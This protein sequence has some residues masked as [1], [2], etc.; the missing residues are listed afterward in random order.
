MILLVDKGPAMRKK[1]CDMLNRER[2]IGVAT[3]QQVLETLV[4]H[5]NRLNVFIADATS[6][7]EILSG[8]TILKL[9][10][11][12]SIN[13]PPI[14]ALYRPGQEAIIQGIS[15]SNFQ[16]E[17]V[18]FDEKDIDFPDAYTRAIKTVYPEV[19]IDIQKANK[20]WS[21]TDAT[22]DL[23]DVKNWLHKSGF[24]EPPHEPASRPQVEKNKPEREEDNLQDYKKLYLDMKEKYDKL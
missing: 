19:N 18:K 1:L 9:C 5:K 4:L 7:S 12:L 21:R 8:E 2:I 11:K 6:L 15:N 24:G 17:F 14:V 10:I 23:V 13:I 20:V 3:K 16:F 22:Q